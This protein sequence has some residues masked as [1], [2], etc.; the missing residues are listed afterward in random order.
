MFKHICKALSSFEASIF[1]EE[2][3][4]YGRSD[5]IGFPLSSLDK[6]G[7]GMILQERE[8]D[9]VVY[10][11]TNGKDLA[12]HCQI[13]ETHKAPRNG[14][15]VKPHGT[16]FHQYSHSSRG[17]EGAVAKMLRELDSTRLNREVG[18]ERAERQ[19][20]A[21]RKQKYQGHG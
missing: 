1:D 6:I 3:Q 12:T 8:R 9:N 20:K 18:R 13:T 21:L 2:Q 14:L 5:N 4:M 10:W 19:E 15:Y 17:Q 7:T 16:Y 11:K